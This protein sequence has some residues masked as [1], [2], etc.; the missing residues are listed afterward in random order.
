VAVE[1]EHIVTDK[2]RHDRFRSRE[3][4]Q[5]PI[6]PYFIPVPYSGDESAS[7]REYLAI[8]SSHRYWILGIAAAALTLALFYGAMST[9]V[10]R[11]DVLLAPAG[12]E[13]D[14]TQPL[15]FGQFGNLAS[16][17]GIPSQSS[18]NVHQSLATLKSRAFLTAFIKENNLLP[19]LFPGNRSP[20]SSFWT[21]A[22]EQKATFLDGYELLKKEIL[23]VHADRKT[24]LVTLSVRWKDADVAARWA[25]ALVQ[26]LNRYQQQAAIGE[27]ERSIAYLNDQLKQTTVVELQQVIYH[28]VETETKKIMLAN[29]RSEYAFKIIDPAV[30]AEKPVSPDWPILVALGTIGGIM[31]A[32]FVAFLHSAVANSNT[33]KSPV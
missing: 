15:V 16:L 26:R 31:L 21:A 22:S 2:I 8:L 29:V 23:S 1:K 28:L 24:G 4:E 19:V 33:R 13:Q 20:R 27:A 9:P 7:L 3:Y 14:D 32:V 5:S 6:N 12:E 17:A 18:D 11:A 30:A 10:Y 25:N